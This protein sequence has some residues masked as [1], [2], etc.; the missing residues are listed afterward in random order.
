MGEEPKAYA[1]PI[2]MIVLA[3]TMALYLFSYLFI[4]EARYIVPEDNIFNATDP[5]IYA[6][7]T[8][9][10][11]YEIYYGGVLLEAADTLENYHKDTPIYNSIDDVPEELRVFIE[12]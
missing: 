3:I 10:D 9:N 4:F 1:K 11:T 6:I 5:S 12:H 7:I 2:N 8:E